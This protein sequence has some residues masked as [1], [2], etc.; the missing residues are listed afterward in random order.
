MTTPSQALKS[1][2]E[3]H[4]KLDLHNIESGSELKKVDGF[5]WH[6]NENRGYFLTKVKFIGSVGNKPILG[7]ASAVRLPPH[8]MKNFVLDVAI[9]GCDTEEPVSEEEEEEV[10]EEVQEEVPA[11]VEVIQEDEPEIVKKLKLKKRL[12]GMTPLDKFMKSEAI[13]KKIKN[14]KKKLSLN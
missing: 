6:Y 9:S 3:S 14:N 5:A 7:K 12:G 11:E 10:K 4:P 13:R 1:Y 2:K 8:V